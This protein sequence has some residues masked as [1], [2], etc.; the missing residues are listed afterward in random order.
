[1]RAAPIFDANI[2]PETYQV[3]VKVLCVPEEG[4]NPTSAAARFWLHTFGLY[5]W[6]LPELEV[7]DVPALYAES[8]MSTLNRWAL[9]MIRGAL[10]KAG[11]LLH[12]SGSLPVVCRLVES[13]DPYWSEGGPCLRLVVERVNFHCG[14]H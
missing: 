3:R 13:P 8:A 10:M 9:Y 2:T 14:L 7:R 4:V 12:D 5:Q 11:D 1:M 6:S